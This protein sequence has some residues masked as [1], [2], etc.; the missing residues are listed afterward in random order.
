MMK[1]NKIL[2]ISSLIYLSACAVPAFA[3]LTVPADGISSFSAEFEEVLP[4]CENGTLHIIM[5]GEM[6]I[7]L[8]PT[9]P[10]SPIIPIVKL[11]GP[12]PYSD[13]KG[14]FFWSG[15]CYLPPYDEPME[16]DATMIQ[17]GTT[18]LP[19]PDVIYPYIMF[20]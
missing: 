15:T 17:I 16:V 6:L 11:F 14:S 8:V 7:I 18:L 12:I 19:T 2:F 20:F 3:T 4:I 1:I 10:I 5:S 9:V 13:A